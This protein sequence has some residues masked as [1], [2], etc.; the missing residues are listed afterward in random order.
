MSRIFDRVFTIFQYVV[1]V[2]VSII[3]AVPL[4]SCLIT[5][6]KTNS[7]LS[8][9][10]FLS[11]P[12]NLLLFDNY[13]I[14]INSG[15]FKALLTTAVIILISVTLSALLNSMISYALCRL[16]FKGKKFV[17]CLIVAASFIPTVTLQIYVF[18]I[19]VGLNLVNSLFGYVMIISNIDIISIVIFNQYFSTISPNLDEAAYLDGC[20][21]IGVFFRIHLPLLKQ[22]FI[23][24]AIIRGIFVYN[25]YYIAN[26]YLLDSS[27]YQSVNTLLN[28][29]KT[30]YGYGTQYNVICA[31]VM[32]VALPT[33]IVFVVFQKRIY[34]GL[35]PQKKN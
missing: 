4:Y 3:A 18:R 19:M 32:L 17:Y 35:S 33:V 15:Y 31:G 23:T 9:K 7:E 13:G 16:R 22:A 26:I 14:I 20:S 5:S 1:L 28:M 30:P 29:F 25:E 34:N 8:T 27:K 10:P 11:P 2:L 21:S 24:V 6:L 12:N